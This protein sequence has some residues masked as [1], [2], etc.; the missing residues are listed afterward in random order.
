MIQ[1]G[2]H[3]EVVAVQRSLFNFVCMAFVKQIIGRSAYGAGGIIRGI[4]PSLGH[5]L[6]AEQ[7]AC[8][9]GKVLLPQGAK[10]IGIPVVLDG[11]H[12]FLR[13]RPVVRIA[14]PAKRQILV[15]HVVLLH[16]EFDGDLFGCIRARVVQIPRQLKHL[17]LRVPL[18]GELR[19]GGGQ[20]HGGRQGQIYR[21]TRG[22]SRIDSAVLVFLALVH[23]I[24]Q[25]L[26]GIG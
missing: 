19:A 25:V 16:G 8:G 14:V 6:S 7:D 22:I 10:L 13:L 4:Q 21:L 17:Q 9:Q 12:L 23:I 15:F 11:C 24:V 20:A 2:L 3:I 1:L 5:L 18:L 26:V